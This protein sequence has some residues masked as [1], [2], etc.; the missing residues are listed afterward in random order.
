MKSISDK[1]LLEE[2]DAVRFFSDI[3]CIRQG[4]TNRRNPTLT[5]H[6]LHLLPSV[7]SV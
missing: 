2:T 6:A 7:V 4:C 1:R 3:Y 5:E